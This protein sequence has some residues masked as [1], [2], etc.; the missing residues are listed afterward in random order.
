MS[1][2]DKERSPQQLAKSRRDYLAQVKM[3][4]MEERAQEVAKINR[5]GALMSSAPIA[6]TLS[7]SPLALRMNFIAKFLRKQLTACLLWVTLSNSSKRTRRVDVLR[8]PQ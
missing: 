5:G 3:L 7:S 2:G 1:Q 4:T 8:L 6:S